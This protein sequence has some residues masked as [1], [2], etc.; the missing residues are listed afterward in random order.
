MRLDILAANSISA[1]RMPPK[2]SQKYC[3]PFPPSTP[4]ISY[5]PKLGQLTCDFPSRVKSSNKKSQ[6]SRLALFISI[7]CI[8]FLRK[9]PKNRRGISNLGLQISYAS[10]NALAAAPGSSA[11]KIAR[12]IMTIST[13][14]F[15]T[16]GMR[17][18]VNPPA[19]ATFASK[20]VAIMPESTSS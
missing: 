10:L 14:Y 13:L 15:F 12:P 9:R 4:T 5:C 2:I 16:S 20:P 8:P 6:V 7:H 11:F 18:S 19:T 3:N 1:M 17:S